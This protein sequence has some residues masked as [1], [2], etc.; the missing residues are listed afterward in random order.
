MKL[1]NDVARCHG[2]RMDNLRHADLVAQ[3]KNCARNRQIKRDLNDLKL[4]HVVYI[5]APW[6]DER[7]DCEYKIVEKNV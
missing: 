4:E 2:V 5:A 7:G 3:C 6:F 1:S